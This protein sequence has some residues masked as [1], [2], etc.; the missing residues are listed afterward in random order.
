MSCR[1]QRLHLLGPIWM[2]LFS[3]VYWGIGIGRPHLDASI[4]LSIL[5]NW[6]WQSPNTMEWMARELGLKTRARF[7][8]VFSTTS[9]A[10]PRFRASTLRIRWNSHTLRSPRTCVV[11]FQYKSPT[12]AA[13]GTPL[14]EILAAATAGAL[15]HLRFSS[16]RPPITT[17]YS[18]DTRIAAV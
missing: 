6:N 13:T 16:A 7:P 5:R 9:A 10:P 15:P 3:S 8:R 12:A 18:P 17:R 1:E 11:P 2:L 4:Q 14:P